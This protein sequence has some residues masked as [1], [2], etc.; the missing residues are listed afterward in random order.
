MRTL[1]PLL[2]FMFSF[3]TANAQLQLAQIFA[4]HMV[5]Q[6]DKPLP[7]WGWA[8]PGTTVTVVLD[9]VT[10]STKTNANGQWKATLRPMD[11]G[12]PFVLKVSADKTV[13]EFKDVFIG[14]VW[15]CSGQSNME[16]PVS[17][18]DNAITEIKRA[19]DGKI[20]HIKLETDL[21]LTPKE[22]IARPRAS[23]TVCSPQ[24]VPD[25]TAAGYFF[26]RQLREQL[27]EDVAIGLVNSTWGGSQAEAWIS[28]DGMAAT[29]GLKEHADNYPA[30]WELADAALKARV[31]RYCFGASGIPA[32]I[33]DLE[34]QYVLPGYDFTKWPAAQAPLSWDWQGIWAFRGRGY[35]ACHFEIA[36]FLTDSAATLFLGETDNIQQIL[37]NNTVLEL[38][39]TDR[40]AKATVPPGV[41]KAGKNQLMILLETQKEPHWAGMGLHGDGRDIKLEWS[42]FSL[43]LAGENWYIM[44]SWVAEHRFEHLQNNVA[45]T[46]YNAMIHPLVPM[47]MR[48][49][50]WY[51]G[52]SNAARAFQ[53]RETFPAMIN[54]WRRAWGE[55]FP[56]LFVQ[57]TA[58][59]KDLSANA[60]SWWAELREAQEKT[61]ELPNTAMAVTL[62]IGNP[63][64]IHPTNK[65][66]VGKRLALSA[67]EMTYNKDVNG[68]SPRLLNVEW[69]AA[70]ALLNFEHT[71]NTGL[72]VKDKY[73]YVRGFE[74]AGEDRKFH[75]AQA[76]II[77]GRQI[78]VTHPEGLKPVAVRY[79]WS[80][81]PTD[82]NVYNADGLPLGT[83]RTDNW[84]GV[85]EASKF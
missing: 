45:A 6:R 61:L 27:G 19:R 12:G 82:A 38:R 41:L 72:T 4:D 60:G 25:F 42:D 36:E 71:G 22:D 16:W 44:P 28:R 11:A 21:S 24:T 57:L 77:N 17:Q 26:A 62:D 43:P 35:M 48:G 64:D 53:Y 5:L 55:D 33:A 58:F 67:L 23:W 85:T 68:K 34:A 50:I 59:G 18:S 40:R 14:E 29:E 8:K 83:F 80:D 32:D 79:A 13:L 84:K 7:V 31:A 20:R 63:N 37:V 76:Q 52:E 10:Q 15:L 56:F 73:G 78:L 2:T 66:D 81:A 46:L 9:N 51:Q 54:D 47:A 30:N 69:E 49:A 75:Y 39:Y 1:L 65:Q 70:S 3:L 74:V